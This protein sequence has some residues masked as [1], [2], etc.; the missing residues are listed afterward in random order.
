LTSADENSR[1][2]YIAEIQREYARL[3]EQRANKTSSKKYL[4]LKDARANKLKLD[5][6]RYVPPVPKFLG[7]KVFEN[8]DLS[9]LSSYID[10]TPFFLSWE[11]RG[12]YPEILDDAVAGAEARSLFEDAKALLQR[13]IAGKWLTARAVIGLFPVNADDSDS[14][15]VFT[16]EGR[17]KI[18]T[19]FHFLRQ[20]TLKAP[21]Q[22][23]MCLT[24]F[25]APSTSGVKDYL[26]AF[27]LTTGI[28]IEKQVKHFQD[29]HDDYSAIILKSLADRLAEAFAECMHQRVR[30]EFW[31]YAADESLGKEDMI[32]EKYQGIRPA[33]GYPACPEHTEKRT[34]WEL[35]SVN[36]NTGMELTGSCAMYPAA[37]VSGFY[38]SHPESRYFTTGQLSK[39]QVKDYARR[40]GTTAEQ[41][42]K[43]LASVLNYDV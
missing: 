20:Q 11:L 3:R 38:F 37:S 10:W 15:H 40:K 23:N 2:R 31:G 27:A 6:G 36:E 34:I 14:L 26:G 41:M 39:D 21:G 19:S 7:V 24:D 12:R 35:L 22:P 13:A 42:E 28:G 16:D 43:W 18:A 4:P 32:A 5:W 1:Q 25:V 29:Q 8:Y 9:E 33:P 17:E 30:K